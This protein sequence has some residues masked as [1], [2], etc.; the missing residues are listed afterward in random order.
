M[1]TAADTRLDSRDEERVS[2]I[3]YHKH[4]VLM[5]KIIC[6]TH[7]NNNIE[8]RKCRLLEPQC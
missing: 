8:T 2:S 7:A 5:I 4:I 6:I 1:P 3:Q